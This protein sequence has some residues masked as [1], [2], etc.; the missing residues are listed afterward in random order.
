M[1]PDPGEG[2]ILRTVTRSDTGSASGRD[3]V[4]GGVTILWDAGEL[5]DSRTPDSRQIYTAVPDNQG[6]LNRL[7]FTT[8][9]VATLDP[10]LQD[11]NND[12]T[13]LIGFVR[14]EGRYWKLGDINHSNPIALGPPDQEPSTM[15]PGYDTFLVN[16]Q[17]RRKVIYVGANDGMLHCFDAV[18]G[19]EIWG[20]IPYN[21]L[22]KLKNMWAVD[23]A[24]GGRYFLRDTYVDGSM[25]TADVYI[26][27]DGIGGSEWR[28]ILICGQ[29]PGSGSA[30]AGGLNYYF[31]LDVTD[32]YDPRPL[33]EFTD[34]TMGESW[35]VPVVGKALVDRDPTYVAFM[36]S[37]YDNDMASVVGNY[38]YAVEMET[39]DLLWSY[40]A[41]DVDTSASYP[42][43]PNTIPGS[44]SL[45][46]LDNDTMIDRVYFADLDGR[47]YRLD[48]SQELAVRQ[49][50]WDRD[51]AVIYEDA[52]NYPIVTLTTVWVNPSL[53]G[54]EVRI[55]FGTGGD[56][57][58]PDTTTYSFVALVDGVNPFV[59]WFMGDAILLNLDPGVDMGDLGVGEKIWSDPIV[60]NYTV[61]F[62]TLTG[63]IESVDPCE[64]LA[65]GGKLYARYVEAYSG[66]A[67]GSS[68]FKDASGTLQSLDLA[69]KTRSA[70][71][72]GEVSRVQGDRKRDVYIQEY[73]ST[74][75]KL[76]QPVSAVLR[77]KSWREIY[78]IIR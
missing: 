11:V 7:G 18:T 14:G 38:F 62:N 4:A 48:A 70:V 15:G 28:T 1:A 43:I 77:I 23:A 13:G 30:V 10:Y 46:D 68:A 78:R 76:E 59:E 63:K 52:S 61:Y 73:D 49:A 65:G 19:E 54:T 5:L 36:G 25:M 45:I 16:N 44:P 9:N 69:S 22:P 34:P 37:G 27:A 75:Q 74:I 2:S 64:N 41:P 57:R 35:S 33:W 17:N 6:D 39:G 3:I 55:Y 26:D 42:N 32:P 66:S 20:Y 72:V 50:T 56:D 24:T 31:A 53:W 71:T 8:A 60:A 58:A 51:I 47:V 67:V 40:E 12:N 21:L 29:G